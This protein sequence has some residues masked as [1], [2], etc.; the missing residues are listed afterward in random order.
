M[1]MFSFLIDHDRSGSGISFLKMSSGSGAVTS[2][3]TIGDEQNR[4]ENGTI[5]IQNNFKTAQTKMAKRILNLSRSHLTRLF[6]NHKIK[7]SH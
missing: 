6:Y 5:N 4:K 3:F 2:H 7:L 1:N